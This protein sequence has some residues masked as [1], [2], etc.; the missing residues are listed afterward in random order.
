MLFHKR[1]STN[2]RLKLSLKIEHSVLSPDHSMST[3]TAAPSTTNPEDCVPGTV[4]DGPKGVTSVA[5]VEDDPDNVK[6]EVERARR[7]T[8]KCKRIYETADTVIEALDTLSE[9]IKAKHEQ[10]EAI[11]GLYDVMIETFKIAVDKKV[12][13]ERGYFTKLFDE[14]VRQSEECYVFLSNYMFK[15]VLHQVLSFWNTPS[16]IAEFNTAFEQLK[17][18]F[19]ETQIEFT[20]VTIINTQKAV[21]SL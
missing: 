4:E 12:L 18:R 6:D 7:R 2:D 10:D 1:K 15:G 3:S 8:E 16:K 21:E 9:I 17:K 5:R 14:I 13:N 11:V 19:V 20:A